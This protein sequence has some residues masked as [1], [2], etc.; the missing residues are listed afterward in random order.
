[1]SLNGQPAIKP[2]DPK[3]EIFFHADRQGCSVKWTNVSNLD[4]AM[5][6]IEMA[7]RAIEDQR[8]DLRIAARMQAVQQQALEQQVNRQILKG[9]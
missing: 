7:K 1:M 3:L 6:M 5:A 8:A 2:E 4:F 9:H